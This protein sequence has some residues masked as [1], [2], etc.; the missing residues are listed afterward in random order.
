M[1]PVSVNCCAFAILV[2]FFSLNKIKRLIPM[3]QVQQDLVTVLTRRPVFDATQ[4]ASS[5]AFG[6]W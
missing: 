2:H 6:C 1:K 4:R 3:S 5:A